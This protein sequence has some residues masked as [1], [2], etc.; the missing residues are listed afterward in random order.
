[1]FRS[2]QQG[3]KHVGALERFDLRLNIPFSVLRPPPLGE[4]DIGNAC[5]DF[6]QSLCLVNRHMQLPYGRSRNRRQDQANRY[7]PRPRLAED[8]PEKGGS[9]AAPCGWWGG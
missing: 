2:G 8:L 7:H 5:L 9:Q 1:N 4:R 3:V 6:Y